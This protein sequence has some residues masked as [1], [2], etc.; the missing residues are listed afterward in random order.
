MCAS[1]LRLPSAVLGL[2]LWAAAT[3]AAADA[4]QFHGFLSQGFVLSEGNNVNGSSADSDGS[5]RFQEAGVNA[6]WRP[7]PKLLLAGQLASVRAGQATDEPLRAEYALADW[8]PLQGEKGRIGLRA[9]KIKL[10]IGFYNDSRDAVFTRPSIL[11]PQ[12]V[13]LDTSGGREFG[14]FSVYGGAF[15]GDWYVGDHALYLEM[16]G[17][18][19]Q[20][21][22]DNAGIAILRDQ[23]QGEFE[24]RRGLLFRLSDDYGGGRARAALSLLHGVKL[25]YASSGEPFSAANRFAQDGD[26]DFSQV[27]LSLQ[28][29]WPRL[30]LTA[31]YAWREFQLDELIP[32][33]PVGASTRVD[34]SPSGAYL[35]GTW[36]MTPRWSSF[37]RYDEQIR[38]SQDRSGREQSARFGQPRHYF[39]AHDWTVGQRYDLRPNLALWAEF[40]YVDGVAWVNPLDNPD[41]ARGGAE[42]YWNLFAVMLG[43]RF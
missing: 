30:S 34:L 8:T 6:S 40:H 41:F 28:Y 1:P 29:N 26:L 11:L 20:G 7:H 5:L 10:P 2:G 13:Y 39:F 35:Q 16:G 37:L 38:D 43:Y 19:R 18:G 15:Y 4:P 9:G 22:G 21:L 27:V 33:N 25:H 36:R 32:P 23:A 42:R 12:G 31:E 24:A 3:A 14:Y 17:Y